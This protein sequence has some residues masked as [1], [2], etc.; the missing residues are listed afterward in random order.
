MSLLYQFIDILEEI[1]EGKQDQTTASVK[2][3]EILKRIYV[4]SAL[5]K[6]KKLDAAAT[7]TSANDEVKEEPKKPVENVSYAQ[8]KQMMGGK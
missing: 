2:V 8:F 5:K 7:L 4:D 6:A 3:G 1:E